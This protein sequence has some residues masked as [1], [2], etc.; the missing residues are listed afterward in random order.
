MSD[1][2]NAFEVVDATEAEASQMRKM[3]ARLLANVLQRVAVFIPVQVRI[4]L[5][6]DP[7]SVEHDTGED[8]STIVHVPDS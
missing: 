8:Y 5:R 3:G 1:G 2:G 6:A 7:H 4:G